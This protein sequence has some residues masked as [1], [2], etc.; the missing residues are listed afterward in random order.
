M[1]RP[2]QAIQRAVVQHLE[3][4]GVPKMYWFAVPNG[5]WRSRGR[6][7]HHA[8]YGRAGWRPGSYASFT[9]TKPISLN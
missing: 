6:G 2:E 8:I 5:G 9:T 3:A 4:R 1:K 7:G